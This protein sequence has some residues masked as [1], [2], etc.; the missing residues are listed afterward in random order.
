MKHSARLSFHT[1]L[2]SLV[3]MLL[4]SAF[5]LNA[6]EQ[7]QFRIFLIGDSTMA[8]K[9][10]VDNPEH[11]WG[12]M[13]PM[14]FGRNVAI[15]NH[16]QNGR[17]TKSFID[18]GRW[19]TVYEQLQQGDYVIIQFGHNDA[20]KEDPRRYAPPR[21]EYKEN[22]KKFIREAREKGA[23]PILLTPVTRRDFNSNGE[24]IATHFEYPD[25]MKEVAQEEHVPLIDIFEQ[26]KALIA[27]LG[28]EGSKKL[29]LAGV[30][31]GEYRLWN[32]K[33]DN[34][35]FSR[36]GAYR[37]AELVAKGLASLP[38][39]I[40]A[41]VHIPTDDP[42]VGKGKVVCLDYYFNNEWRAV[43]GKD[44]L[45]RYHY[46]WEDTTNS[47][48]SQLGRVLDWLGADL[49]T[50]QSPPTDSTLRRCSIYIIVD[51]DTPKETAQPHTITS[52]DIAVLKRWVKHG[53]ILLL[54]ANDKGNCEFEHL[55]A[56]AKEFGIQFN[57]D[58]HF[59]VK[60]NQ[61]DMG[62]VTTFPQHPAFS[63]VKHLF[64]KEVTSLTAT[65]PAEPLLVA[66]N[67][68]LIAT[69][70]FGKGLVVAVGDPWLYNEYFDNRRLP[71]GYENWDAGESF[72]R[73]LLREAKGRTCC[74]KTGKCPKCDD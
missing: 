5:V 11:G 69:A 20:K 56:L 26:S 44:T 70:K 10:L 51:P 64:M 3:S 6:P 30:Q 48:F 15:Y 68:V 24:L 35:H 52:D 1:L 18:E 9:P 54:M 31:D 49:D 50:L 71:V 39:P 55:N 58:N 45:E 74:N 32:K 62:R 63:N 72:F 19:N 28:D 40:A 22:L 29:Y 16:A 23:L 61:Y 65:A 14:F 4:F 33:K 60:N 73:W 66:S 37:I 12:Q 53:G 46:T 17:S 25:A 21:P 57:E 2:F 38:L 59:M 13:L 27:P 47:G 41:E 34:T 36:S 8:N 43:K 42:F 67:I 7:K